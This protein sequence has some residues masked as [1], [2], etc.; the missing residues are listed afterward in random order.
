MSIQSM[1]LDQVFHALADST[2]R[3]VLRH[4]SVGPVSVSK[5]AEPFGMALPSFVQHL[6]VLERCK[7]IRSRKKGRIRTYQLSPR[8][9]KEAGDW[10]MQRRSVWEQRLNRLDRHLSKLNE[11]NDD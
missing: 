5:L 10:M 4:L 3:A 1:Q 9:L 8:P 11:E 2:R 6:K 7:L